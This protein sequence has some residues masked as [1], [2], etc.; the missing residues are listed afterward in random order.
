MGVTIHYRIQANKNWT[1]RQ[2]RQ[3]LEDTRRF[4]LALPVVSVGEVVELRGKDCNWQTNAEEGETP[5]EAAARDPYRWVKNPGLSI[6]RIALAAGP[7]SH[8]VTLR[9]CCACRS[10]RPRAA[11]K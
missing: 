3:K 11:S 10:I 1:R 6:P 2:I 5:D 8:A 9:T 7:V 4:A